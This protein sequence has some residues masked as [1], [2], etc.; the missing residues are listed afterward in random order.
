MY[1]LYV[2]LCDD[3]YPNDKDGKRRRGR[4][5]NPLACAECE[6]PCMYG[7]EL[8][9]TIDEKAF[10]E[11]MCGA[12]CNTCIQPCNLR[13]VALMRNIKWVNHRERMQKS[14][15]YIAMKPYYE[16]EARRSQT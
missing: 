5:A 6:S 1:E 9:K 10:Q 11:L 16:R 8:L 2:A 3:A 4:M 13:R 12:D 14:W 7:I 15:M